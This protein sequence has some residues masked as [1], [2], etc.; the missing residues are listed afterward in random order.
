[1]EATEKSQ[2]NDLIGSSGRSDTR[3]WTEVREVR[4]RQ[5]GQE[6]QGGQGASAGAAAWWVPGN[7]QQ[8]ELLRLEREENSVQHHIIT[9]C[10]LMNKCHCV[11]LNV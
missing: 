7:V 5:E 9:V 1:M 11:E 6:G 10:S 3:S 4:E 8:P 2:I